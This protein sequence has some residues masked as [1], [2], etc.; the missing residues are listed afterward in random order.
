MKISTPIAAL[1][2]ALMST[3]AFAADL[4]SRKMAPAY[5]APAPV[6]TWSGFYVGL[7]AGALWDQLQGANNGA[8]AW[9]ASTLFPNAAN[10]LWYG[11]NTGASTQSGFVGGG[12]IGYNFQT[13]PA[14]FG[15]EG[16]LEGASLR[17]GSLRGSLRG[18]LGF[19]VDRVLFY[20]TGGLAF[21]ARNGS[22]TYGA[23]GYNWGGNTSSS[24]M[25][26]TVGAGV[27]YAFTQAWS[28]GLEYRYSQFSGNSGNTGYFGYNYGGNTKINEN[29]VRA[30]LSYHFGAPSAPVVAKY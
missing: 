23:Y 9:W 17:T 11:Y 15:L 8:N 13:G 27:E 28:A 24:R 16:D 29:A 10:T 7:Q 20:G 14:V 4:P 12:H 2:G 3:T 25:G 5:I 21:G 6:F 22:S 26:W 19:A 30:R 1:V 18:R